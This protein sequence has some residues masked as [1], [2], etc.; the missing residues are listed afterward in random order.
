MSRWADLE[1][2]TWPRA[3]FQ[4]QKHWWMGRD[5]VISEMIDA[6]SKQLRL[7]LTP[8]G[9]KERDAAKVRILNFNRSSLRVWLLRGKWLIFSKNTVSGHSIKTRQ[10]ELRK[11]YA[12]L[13][14]KLKIVQKVILEI[15]RTTQSV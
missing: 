3:L 11:K 12:Q 4:A 7:W 2:I 15:V 10:W 8:V 9:I 14:R 13:F 1:V 5:D 6:H